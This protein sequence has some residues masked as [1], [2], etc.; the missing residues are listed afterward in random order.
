MTLQRKLVLETVKNACTHPNAT[1]VYDMV[2]QNHS[3]SL[4][5]VYNSLNYLADNGFIRRVAIAG[6]ADR[7]DGNTNVHY[8]AKCDSCGKIYDVEVHGIIDDIQ[9]HY[10][11]KVTSFG[12]NLHCICKDCQ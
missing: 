5:T 8:H 12:I 4:A 10:G 7:F 11:I 9:K 1:E 6:D 3:V 2:R